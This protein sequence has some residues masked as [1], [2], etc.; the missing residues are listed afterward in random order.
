[1]RQYRHNYCSCVFL[2]ARLCFWDRCCLNS[3]LQ[4]F[5]YN[6][7]SLPSRR[8]TF[9]VCF[10]ILFPGCLNELW[11]LCEFEFIMGQSQK[12]FSFL[13]F[14]L[15]LLWKQSPDTT[16]SLY[17]GNFLRKKGFATVNIDSGFISTYEKTFFAHALHRRTIRTK[18][19]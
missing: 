19:S 5:R 9:Q 1:M 3:T 12:F 10:F 16:I 8:S 17:F 11:F 13:D 7:Y 6:I 15:I 4:I 14:V 18:P 2:C